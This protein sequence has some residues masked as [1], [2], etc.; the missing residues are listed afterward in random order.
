MSLKLNIKSIFKENL[1][2]A[3]KDSSKALKCPSCEGSYGHSGECVVKEDIISK[4]IE[5]GSKHEKE[6]HG[7]SDEMASKIAIDHIKEHPNYY[8]KLAQCDLDEE[9]STSTSTPLASN[10]MQTPQQGNIQGKDPS[11]VDPNTYKKYKSEV[12]NVNKKIDNF[13]T[14]LQTLKKQKM[15]LSKKYGINP[16]T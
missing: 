9:L 5:I 13:T 15:D 4:E 14:Q 2:I 11:Q 3:S 6:E 7:L 16:N 1:E 8:S 10:T 12:D